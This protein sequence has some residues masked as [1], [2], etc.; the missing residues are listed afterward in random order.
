MLLQ[1]SWEKNVLGRG[2]SQYKGH[3]AEVCLI[4]LG[5]NKEV[6]VAEALIVTASVDTGEVGEFGEWSDSTLA[7]TLTEMH[8]IEE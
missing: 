2:E 1:S 4:Y 3:K 7:S 8:A 5:N 6:C